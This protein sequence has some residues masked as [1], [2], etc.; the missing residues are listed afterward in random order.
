MKLKYKES[1]GIA[2]CR[3][4]KEENNQGEILMI[5]KRYTYHYFSFI[6]AYYKKNNIKQIQYL[7]NNM[8]FEEKLDIF[9]MDFSRMWYRLW[10][11]DPDKNYNVQNIFD[12]KERENNNIKNYN[13]YIK[14]KATFHKNFFKDSGKQ[15]RKIISQSTHSVTPWEIPKGRLSEKDKLNKIDC[16]MREFKEETCIESNLYKII[17]DN[18]PIIVSHKDNNV[19]YKSNYYIA[20]CND[21]CEKMIIPKITFTF[22]NQ[23]NEVQDVK[24]ISLNNIKYLGLNK[25]SENR[26]INTYKKVINV[27]KKHKKK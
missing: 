4:N 7:F 19:I 2:L 24:W 3:I 26:L 5:K 14:K 13:L 15:L 20:C 10:L 12:K 8:T 11:C 9:S 25:K 27:F 17:W 1:Y 22:Y 6:F 16:A 23:I 21:M 18:R